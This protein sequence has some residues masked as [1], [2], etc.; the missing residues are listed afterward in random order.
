ML[1]ATLSDNPSFLLDLEEQLVASR[2]EIEEAHRR[3]IDLENRHETLQRA[4][5][6]AVAAV[7]TRGVS[8][9]GRLHDIL[10]HAREVATHGISYGVG[11]TLATTQL[12]LGHELYHLEPSFSDTNPL[13]DQEDLIRDFTDAVE[14]IA[15]TIHAQNVV[16]NVFLGP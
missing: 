2:R 13:E 1:L 6:G 5:L 8:L 4:A 10:V 15:V 14:A 12:H 16:H 7:N 3:E 11:A 9:E